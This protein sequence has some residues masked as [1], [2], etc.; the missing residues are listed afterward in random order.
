MNC[1]TCGNTN[2]VALGDDGKHY[3][4]E[5][6]NQREYDAL[7]GKPAKYWGYLDG[8]HITTWTGMALAY[9]VSRRTIRHNMAG[10]MIAW[11]ARDNSGQEWYGRSVGDGMSTTM[12][13]AKH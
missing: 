10:K 3:C 1:A 9:V 8:K 12:H 11:R 4:R 7:M 13:K 5:C 2:T 6:A